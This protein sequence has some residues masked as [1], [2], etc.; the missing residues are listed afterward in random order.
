MYKL[1]YVVTNKA[2]GYYIGMTKGKLFSRF[3]HHKH[4]CCRGVKNKLYDYMRKYG[5]ESFKIVLVAEYST[6]KECCDAE[7]E[8]IKVARESG[9]K[10]LNLADGGEG[11]FNVQDKFSWRMKLSKAR[12]GRKPALGM[13]HS[14][15]N[16]K[17]FSKLSTEYW[18]ENRTYHKYDIEGLSFKEARD[19]YGISKTHFY[20][21]KRALSNEQC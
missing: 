2:N 8:A 6:H 20:R 15:E 19:L 3:N 17:L 13:K 12:K 16:K 5:V 18:E 4:S 7:I 1:Y 10:L 14:E 9:H 21:L 11:G